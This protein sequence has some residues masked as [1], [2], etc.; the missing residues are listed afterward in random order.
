[1]PL[2][3]LRGERV[4]G[5]R[6][7]S[8]KVLESLE[9]FMNV[10]IGCKIQLDTLFMIP[11]GLTLSNTKKLEQAQKRQ[12]KCE[13]DECQLQSSSI[14]EVSS[15]DKVPAAKRLQSSLGLIHDKNKCVWCCK[16]ESVKHPVSKLLLISYD[17]A[18]AAFKS[19]T[20][21]LEDQKMCDRINCLVDS[22]ADKPYAL[23]IRYHHKCW[24]KYV[25][26]FQKMSEDDKLLQMQNNTYCE[27]QTMFFDHTRKVIFEEHEYFS[28]LTVL[29]FINDITLHVWSKNSLNLTDKYCSAFA[30]AFH[31]RSFS[32]ISKHTS[33]SICD[34]QEHI[35]LISCRINQ[36]VDSVTH[37]LIFKGHCVALESS[38]CMII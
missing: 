12:K 33:A 28:F 25:W 26:K 30:E 31:L 35:G 13:L 22:A 5:K 32:G 10:Q 18:W 14:A 27:V 6:L 21:V 19:H 37:I 24:L 17:H 38:P 8:G 23:E 15:Q 36:T 7:S 9:M 16:P 34:D 4:S 11:S 2:V 20:V 3:P 29:M 1:M